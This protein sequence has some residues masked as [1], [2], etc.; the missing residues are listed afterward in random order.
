MAMFHLILLASVV[1]GIVCAAPPVAM[2]FRMHSKSS[3]SDLD[4]ALLQ[5]SSPNHPLYRQHMSMETL[6]EHVGARD[7]CIPRVTSWLEAISSVD[8]SSIRLGQFL[9]TIFFNVLSAE[10]VHQVFGLTTSAPHI[11]HGKLTFSVPNELSDCVRFV[12]QPIDSVRVKGQRRNSGRFDASSASSSTGFPGM[13]QTPLTIHQRYQIPKSHIDVPSFAQAVAEFEGEQF[14]QADINS[15]LDQ[16]GFANNTVHV[17]GPNNGGYF[18]E[19]VMD[20]EVIAGV[21]NGAAT[22]WVA[23]NQFDFVSWTESYVKIKP[24][25]LV[26]SISWG[27]GEN[28]YDNAS[29]TAD[30]EEFRKLGLLG[31]SVLVSS[32]DDGTGTTGFFSCGTFN[33]T[34]PATSPYVTA[35]GGTYANSQSTGEIGWGDSGGG[36][37]TLFARPA[38]QQRAVEA[39]LNNT[40]ASI[41]STQYFNP[42]GRGFPDVSAVACNF[43]VFAGGAWGEETGTSA[44]APTFAGVISRIVAS[45]L[46]QGKS[47]LG[48]LNPTLYSQG[49]VGYDVVQGNNVQSPCPAGFSAVDGWDAISGLGTPSYP[50]LEQIFS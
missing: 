48:F 5:R 2:L 46:S 25:P 28:G 10:E 26:A 16:Y 22:W 43:A 8:R 41:P 31:V 35:V 27:S 24:L 29:M 17:V 49:H 50:V 36:F 33:P 19:G 32:G 4:T 18:D 9:D 45:R 6:R 13:K 15:F 20:L 30:S 23:Q 39:Y 21:A 34:F 1:V 38:Y 37:S 14:H 3:D 11:R 40:N 42:G 7:G 12:F 44:A 47:S